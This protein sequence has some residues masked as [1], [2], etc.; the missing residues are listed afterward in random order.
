MT[1][2]APAGFWRRYAAYSLDF[3]A[4]GIVA[5]LLAWTRLVAGWRATAAAVAALSASLQA[6]LLDALASGSPPATLYARLLHTP[7]VQSGAAAVQS[8]LLSMATSWLL[9]YAVIAALYHVGFERFR[10]QG[11]PGKHALGLRVVAMDGDQRPTLAQTLVRHVAGALS[12]LSLNLGHAL[13]A[14]A[15]QKRA[16]HDYIA[17][18]RVI[19]PHAQPLPGWARAWLWLQVIAVLLAVAWLLQ[20]DVA[21]L[22]ASLE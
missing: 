22:Q 3:T 8:G 2:S 4:L 17:G 6:P 12:W 5:T 11:S 14:V 18:T 15:P 16:L 1:S 9:V 19:Q 21:A 7:A 10:W 13:A 20:R